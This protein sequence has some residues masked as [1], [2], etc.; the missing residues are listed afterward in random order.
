MSGWRT[1]S[2]ERSASSVSMPLSVRT[3]PGSA[4][5]NATLAPG[6]RLSTSYGPIASSAVNLSYR[7]IAMFM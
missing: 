3:G 2:S 1:S 7:T 6:S 4:A 5:T